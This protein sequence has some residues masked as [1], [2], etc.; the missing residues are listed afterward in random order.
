M[1]TDVVALHF[2]RTCTLHSAHNSAS[3]CVALM[4]FRLRIHSINQLTTVS[5]L[6]TYWTKEHPK[7]FTKCLTHAGTWGVGK[8]SFPD[9]NS[10]MWIFISWG[11]WGDKF[12]KIQLTL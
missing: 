5:L 3:G 10:A 1:E 2:N 7:S 4:H 9:L 11:Q 12:R 8:R 6:T